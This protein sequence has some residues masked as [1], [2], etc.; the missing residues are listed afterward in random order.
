[1]CTYLWTYLCGVVG[2]N[3][4]GKILEQVREEVRSGRDMAQWLTSYFNLCDE[5][6]A[7]WRVEVT[8]DGKRLE[9]DDVVEEETNVLMVGKLDN[10]QVLC[11]MFW[12]VVMPGLP[13]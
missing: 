4:Y 8:R 10:C 13:L 6:S 1:M 5:K 9:S 11:G 12:C 2:Q 7:A 3:L